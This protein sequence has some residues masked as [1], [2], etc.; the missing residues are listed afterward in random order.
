[1]VDNSDDSGSWNLNIQMHRHVLVHRWVICKSSFLRVWV[2]NRSIFDRNHICLLLRSYQASCR[3]RALIPSTVCE[4]EN[5]VSV[6]TKT[7]LRSNE[8]YTNE[9]GCSFSCFSAGQQGAVG[10]RVEPNVIVCCCSTM[11]ETMFGCKTVVWL[12]KQSTFLQLV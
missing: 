1:M 2:K 4:I 6:F 5:D 11:S 9:S 7:Q 3:R 12:G 8:T 10:A